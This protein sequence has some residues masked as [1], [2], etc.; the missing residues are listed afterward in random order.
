M[1]VLLI[2]GS[3]RKITG[4]YAVP[5]YFLYILYEFIFF[6][7]TTILFLYAITGVTTGLSSMDND[8]CLLL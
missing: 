6:H 3:I 5:F 4:L 7:F 8:I 1:S 2:L